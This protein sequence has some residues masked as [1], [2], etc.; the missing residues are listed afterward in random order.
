MLKADLISNNSVS[1]QKLVEMKKTNSNLIS[2][3]QA[4]EP[5]KTLVAGSTDSL[6]SKLKVSYEDKKKNFQ[7]AS[8]QS[9]KDIVKQL[10]NKKKKE[11][12]TEEEESK[13]ANEE[14]SID[15]NFGQSSFQKTQ[16]KIV[17]SDF[18][19]SRI[20]EIKKFNKPTQ[21]LP[22]S[23]F[24]QKA[25]TLSKPAD[26][27]FDLEL[28]IG[29]KPTTQKL[30]D[31]SSKYKLGS[32]QSP[33]V[34]RKID[35]TNTPDKSAVSNENL[36]A[37]EKRAKKMKMIE[38]LQ[39]IKSSHSKDVMDPEKNPHYK[40]YLDKLQQQE[41]IDNK[42]TTMR[43]REVKVVSCKVCSYTAFSQS[44]YC[45][46]ERHNI[47][48]RS[49]MQ[50][51]FRCKACKEKMYTLDKVVPSTACSKC[52]MERY[53]PCTMKDDTCAS[54]VLVNVTTNLDFDSELAVL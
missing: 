49:V 30:L 40:S 24:S 1:S 19:K 44:N 48:R 38:E 17:A 11:G 39:G 2:A 35:E 37:E 46:T 47:V 53:E 36:S 4:S 43:S 42:L 10:K 8:M 27:G 18:L 45:K 51:W 21:P 25:P 23:P 32:S 13:E 12:D 15:S 9:H 14:K 3:S 16:N 33:Q 28:Y 5:T 54:N 7:L 34:K 22:S 50:R 6:A 52:G 31:V 26:A 41:D 20:D 29:D